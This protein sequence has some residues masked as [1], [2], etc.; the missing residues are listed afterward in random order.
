VQHFLLQA[1][2]RRRYPYSTR[3]YDDS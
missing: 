2:L 3:S 1:I